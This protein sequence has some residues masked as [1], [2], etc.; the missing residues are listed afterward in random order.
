MPVRIGVDLG[1]TKI[2]IAALDDRNR[3]ILR[4]RVATPVGDY[5][6]TVTAIAA[7]IHDADAE[8]ATTA[9]VGI[10]TPG[11][12]SR[13]TGLMKN[14]NSTVL[15]GRPLKTDIEARVGREVRMT[16]D[17]NCFAL[18]E[19][20]D[21]AARNADVVFGVILGTGVGGGIA[22]G[23]HIIEGPN[24]IAGEWGHNPLP[25]PRSDELPGPKCY[26]GKRGCIETFLSG[27]ALTREYQDLSGAVAVPTDIAARERAGEG[28]AAR[29]M[30]TY[31]DRLARALAH[32]INI[33][34]PD[35][36]VFGGGVSNVREI[37]ARV[38]LLLRE[39]VFSDS[40]RTKLVPAQYGDSSGVRGAAMLWP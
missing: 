20:I 5:E 7:L 11:A 38:P 12:V 35:A 4:R 18:S 1:G 33:L 19:A 23:K 8:L 34:D 2:E 21:G 10:G 16:N 9:S 40:L 14:A 15:I 17:A 37:Y 39:Y 25:W 31:C 27:P 13:E 36:I 22:V 26:C 24:A 32:V 30:T 6:A 29:C 28:A 3:A